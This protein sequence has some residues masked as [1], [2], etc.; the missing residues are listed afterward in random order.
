MNEAFTAREQQVLRLVAKAK[1]NR[2]IAD[3]LGMLVSTLDTHLASIKARAGLGKGA[4]PLTVYAVRWAD[5][6]GVAA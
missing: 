6:Q 2:E 5:A 1:A 4:R 3:E